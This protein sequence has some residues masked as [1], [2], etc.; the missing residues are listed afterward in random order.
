[1]IAVSRDAGREICCLEPDGRNHFTNLLSRRE[2]PYFYAFDVLSLEG[3]DVR[4]LPLL[5]R[6]RRLRTVMPR[7]ETRLLYLDHIAEH[8]RGLFE[9]ACERDLEGIVGKWAHGTYQSDTRRTSWL[10]IKNPDYSQM[11][12]RHE[13]FEPRRRPSRSATARPSL[14]LA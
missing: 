3:K 1:M 11:R 14:H 4:A 2:W 5:E 9:A 13:L 12:D 7:V 10:K 8:G 6:K